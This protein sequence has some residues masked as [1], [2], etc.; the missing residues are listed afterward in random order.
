MNATYIYAKEFELSRRANGLAM[1]TARHLFSFEIT[2]FKQ[3]R[4]TWIESDCC[5]ERKNFVYSEC[6]GEAF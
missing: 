6:L 3:P 5:M 1:A 4:I 2:D